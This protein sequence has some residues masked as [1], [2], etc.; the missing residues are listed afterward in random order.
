MSEQ[1]SEPVGGKKPQARYSEEY[2]QNAVRMVL[3]DGFSVEKASLALGCGR[4]TL[5]RWVKKHRSQLTPQSPKGP[6]ETIRSLR[7]ENERLKQEVEFLKKPQ[8]TLRKSRS[9]VRIHY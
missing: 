6:E 9:E 4:E 1:K 5:R 2:Q 3:E 8:R 7:K